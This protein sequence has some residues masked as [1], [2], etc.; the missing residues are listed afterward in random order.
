MLLINSCMKI[1]MFALKVI[2]LLCF[3]LIISLSASSWHCHFILLIYFCLFELG[4]V[5]CFPK[6]VNH[7][8]IYLSMSQFA[9]LVQVS[10]SGKRLGS[11]YP[12]DSEWVWMLRNVPPSFGFTGTLL[13]HYYLFSGFIHVILYSRV[14]PQF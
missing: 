4:N 7:T 13:L 12:T 3:L 10:F 2:L 9:C 6:E 5:M 8:R 14:N 11:F 1:I